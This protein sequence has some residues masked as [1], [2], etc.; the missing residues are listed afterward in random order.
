[1]FLQAIYKMKKIKTNTN[2][3]LKRGKLRVFVVLLLSLLA[4]TACSI[5]QQRIA[6]ENPE[7]K[8]SFTDSTQ[9]SRLEKSVLKQIDEHSHKNGFYF[10]ATGVEA[11]STLTG[12]ISS[13]ERSIDLQSFLYHDDRTGRLLAYKLLQAADRGVRVRIL[14][15]DFFSSSKI[16]LLATLNAHRNIE[17]RFFNPISTSRWAR[18]LAFIAK[19]RKV[20]RRMHNKAFI[21][22]RHV[23]IIGGRNVGD[24]YYAMRDDYQ[25]TDLDVLSVGPVVKSISTSFNTFWTSRWAVAAVS[26]NQYDR[27]SNGSKVVK[28]KLTQLRVNA[29]KLQRSSFMKAVKRSGVVRKLRHANLSLLWSNS[30]L[31]YDPPEK[32]RGRRKHRKKYLMNQL[33]PYLAQARSEVLIITPYFIPSRS[34]LRWIKR[35]RKKGVKVTILTNSFASNDIPFAYIGYERYRRKVLEMGVE[36]YEFKPTAETKRRK[37]YK[38]LK[39]IPRSGLHAKLIIIDGEKMIIGSPNINPRSRNLDTEIAIMVNSTEIAEKMSALFSKLIKPVN[40]YRV[41]LRKR[42][43]DWKEADD[44]NV[45]DEDEQLV[46]KTNKQGKQVQYRQ[47]PNTG[48]FEHLG[49]LFIGLLPIE[50]F[51]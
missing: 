28:K 43:N 4:L 40:S 38:W 46:W 23:A 18:P 16:S 44:P 8:I 32:V 2:F 25:F 11:F 7:N 42:V 37:T 39:S 51:L 49:I 12:L 35:L 14:L 19:F 10:I 1:M 36:L 15:D 29:K 47:E 30:R 6:A 13:A 3:S 9:M 17:V 26:Y 34:G 41:V 21:V 45:S 24:V 27:T 31:M 5:K 50:G 20:T 33:M 22:D 48:L